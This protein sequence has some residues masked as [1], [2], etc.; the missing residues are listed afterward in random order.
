V[1]YEPTNAGALIHLAR[2]AGDEGRI[3]ALDSLANRGLA[4]QPEK[5]ILLQVR[6]LQAFALGRRGDQ[7]QIL[8]AVAA[9]DPDEPERIVIRV[10]THTGDLTGATNLARLLGSGAAPPPPAGANPPSAG[11]PGAGARTVAVGAG[12]AA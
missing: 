1:F 11:P 10:A 5:V 2:I 12:G 8:D 3:G 4:L 9:L 7:E 6:A